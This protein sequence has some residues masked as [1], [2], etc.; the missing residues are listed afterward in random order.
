MTDKHTVTLSYQVRQSRLIKRLTVQNNRMRD[1]L[2]A[3]AKEHE[4]QAEAWGEDGECEQSKYHAGLAKI[5]R[6]AV[7]KDE[8]REG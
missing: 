4:H 6:K 8:G 1:A 3:L 7:E 2:L 5:A